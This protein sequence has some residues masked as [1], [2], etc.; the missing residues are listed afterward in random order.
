[1]KRRL[2]LIG[3]GLA[4]V[5]IPTFIMLSFYFSNRNVPVAIRQ[6]EKM[7]LEL[8]DGQRL[9][10]TADGTYKELL[11]LFCDM[12]LDAKSVE[13]LPEE[14]SEAG[15]CRVTFHS[16]QSKLTY[17]FYFS[18][19]PAYCYFV[20]GNKSVHRIATEKAQAFLNTEHTE[21]AYLY[22]KAPVLTLGGKPLTPVALDWSYRKLN[23]VYQNASCAGEN[24]DVKPTALGVISGGLQLGCTPTPDSMTLIATNGEGEIVFSGTPE[25]FAAFTVDTASDLSMKLVAEWKKD[26]KGNAPFYGRAEYHLSATVYAPAVFTVSHT[27]VKPGQVF[28]L[29]GINVT[30]PA[31]IKVEITPYVSFEPRFVYQSGEAMAL[32]TLGFPTAYM[33]DC[34]YSIKVRCPDMPEDAV[35]TV[36]VKKQSYDVFRD[37]I[38]KDAAEDTVSLRHKNE[39]ADIV[40]E[41]LQKESSYDFESEPLTFT[42]GVQTPD[43]SRYYHYGTDVKIMATG[44]EYRAL[45]TMYCVYSA[46]KP[47]AVANGRVVAITESALSGKM[48]VIDHGNG[49]RSWYCNLKEITPKVGD[50]V[51]K[52]QVIGTCGGDGF[53]GQ[54]GL[55]MHVALTL[56]SQAI[57][58]KFAIE[59]GIQ[60]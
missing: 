54:G 34:E 19:N 49:I 60:Y 30:D 43:K 53:N 4:I 37:Y 36:T 51:E 57:D 13:K 27:E 18:E 21:W 42:E 39:F 23:G 5:M 55:N 8:P 59:N 33:T 48:L 25:Q 28:T 44:A 35:F 56:G 31:A 9:T 15:L 12:T 29:S 2:S 26:D 50:T 38:K 47:T 24:K 11:S 17:R 3:I 52:G 58:L 40:A 10:A 32:M 6:A 20:A 7:V 16:A 22:A 41:I 14:A 45:D 1:M 46:S